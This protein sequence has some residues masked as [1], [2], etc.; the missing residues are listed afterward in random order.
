MTTCFADCAGLIA[1]GTAQPTS[2]GPMVQQSV[3]SQ[4][5]CESSNVENTEPGR[6]RET[7]TCRAELCCAMSYACV[8]DSCKM[9]IDRAYQVPAQS[10]EKAELVCM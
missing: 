6:A 10:R 4:V 7:C 8:S 5:E 1:A 9:A 2:S 3:L